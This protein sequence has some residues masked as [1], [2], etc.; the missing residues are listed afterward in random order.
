M[1]A[2]PDHKLESI[3]TLDFRH[4]RRIHTL[5]IVKI[6]RWAELLVPLIY[7]LIIWV[8]LK[9]AAGVESDQIKPRHVYVGAGI[10]NGLHVAEVLIRADIDLF[11]HR[12]KITVDVKLP[13]IGDIIRIAGIYARRVQLQVKI[14][15]LRI[16]EQRVLRDISISA[17]LIRQFHV[18]G[19]R[20]APNIII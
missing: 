13:R 18:V 20:V 15:S 2:V 17:R 5:W 8:V 7:H 1:R 4:K 6:H 16:D 19:G 12:S 10:G 9:T 3:F 14:F 11:T